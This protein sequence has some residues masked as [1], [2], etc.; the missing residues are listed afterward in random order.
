MKENYL[1]FVSD[2]FPTDAAFAV[3]VDVLAVLFLTASYLR[4]MTER[5][6]S[7]IE[8]LLSSPC[9]PISSV[10]NDDSVT[11][12]PPNAFASVLKTTLYFPLFGTPIR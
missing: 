2:V 12:E 11:P 3:F 6:A 9:I 1:V 10:L 7:V 5:G 8:M 4:Y